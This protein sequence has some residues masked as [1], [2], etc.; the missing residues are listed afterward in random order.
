MSEP[1]PTWHTP[2]Y[3]TDGFAAPAAGESNPPTTPQ[4]AAISQ[5]ARDAYGEIDM[6]VRL[7][8][9]PGLSITRLSDLQQA[10]LR[11][12]GAQAQLSQALRPLSELVLNSEQEA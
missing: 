2:L 10:L 3:S 5:A 4:D 12:V 8:P 9:Y 11:A 1:G 7:W 6:V